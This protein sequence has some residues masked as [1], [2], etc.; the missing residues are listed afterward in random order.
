MSIG[1]FSE[2]SMNSMYSSSSDLTD[3]EV[4]SFLSISSS[5]PSSHSNGPLYELSDLLHLPIKRGLSKFYEGKAQS[6]TSLAMVERIEDLP[7]KCK[8]QRKR[9]KSCKSYIE[10]LHS[11]TVS[12][13]VSKKG[14]RG[15]N[16]VSKRGVS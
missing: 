11:Q 13:K 12:F 15:P 5:S 7:K 10:G 8:F 6:F 9:M 14:S 2:N 4:T 1:S 3:Q 16:F